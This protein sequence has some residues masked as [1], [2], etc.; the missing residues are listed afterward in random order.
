[1]FVMYRYQHKN[2]RT[3][4]PY[5]CKIKILKTKYSGSSIATYVHIYV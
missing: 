5:V 4:H 2:V 3:Y 1:M